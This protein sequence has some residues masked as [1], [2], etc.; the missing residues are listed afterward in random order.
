MI[1]LRCGYCCKNYLVGIVD[2]LEKGPVP[3]NFTVSKGGG[4]PCKHLQG[5]KPGEYTCLAHNYPWYN[6]TPC[7]DFSQVEYSKDSLCRMG[8]Y[9]LNG[10]KEKIRA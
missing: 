9:V 5:N 1:C 2:D 6:E 3:G 10:F 4:V 8:V 7:Y